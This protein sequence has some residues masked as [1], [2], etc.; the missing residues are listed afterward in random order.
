[1]HTLEQEGAE[2]EREYVRNL[3][4]LLER[5]KLNA[6]IRRRRQ[7][8]KNV[9]RIRELGRGPSRALLNAKRSYAQESQGRRAVLQQERISAMRDWAKATRRALSVALP[10]ELVV[11]ELPVATGA[12]VTLSKV[13]AHS[14][15]RT[16]FEALDLEIDRERL[17]VLG[18]NGAGKT[19]LLQIMMGERAPAQGEVKVRHE[20]LGYVAQNAENWRLEESLLSRLAAESAAASVE[21]L[22]RLLAAHR[23]PFALAERPLRSLSPGERVR[24]ALICLF[25]RRP[26]VECLLLDEPTHD[27]DFLATG[28]FESVLR[29]W[30]GGLVVISHDRAFLEAVGVGRRLFLGTQ[31]E[32]VEPVQGAMGTLA[33]AARNVATTG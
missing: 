15:Q 9:G 22:A 17:A 24:A 31:Q 23:F 7:R 14:G 8:K 27:L 10:L 26:T 28:V 2:R 32:D 16:L 25:Q 29:A 21:D 6:T 13:T 11:P 33:G 1:L 18:P 19:T 20:K 30:R 5:E 4:R 12:V 3:N